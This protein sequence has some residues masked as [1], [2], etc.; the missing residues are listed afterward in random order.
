MV[1]LTKIP[2]VPVRN[3]TSNCAQNNVAF[4]SNIKLIEK[5]I[6][7]SL[8]NQSKV[9]KF[10]NYIQKNEG[11][12]MNILVNAVGT[13]LVAPFFIAFN[14]ISKE[15][16]NTKL[17]SALRQPISAALA[18]ITQVGVVTKFNKYI[19]KLAVN[20]K[21]GKDYD[22]SI[23]P[24]AKY[25]YNQ[26]KKNNPNFTRDQ[27]WDEVKKIRK[28]ARDNAIENLKNK[29]IK[30]TGKSA[31]SAA[32]EAGDTI[33][34]NIST[35]NKRVNGLSKFLGLFVSLAIMPIT[36]TALNWLYPRMMEFFAPS[37]CKD[38]SDNS[39]GGEKCK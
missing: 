14:P 1:K 34:K 9:T 2:N 33:R 35:I 24:F 36:C 32:K 17:Y 26:V 11:E 21:L 22:M 18:I 37:L 39:Q 13:A 16:K 4:G 19:D 38:K 29:I 15:D 10:L 25:T 7:N 27:I 28:E 3:I 5:G 8:I 20:G 23:R 30:E 6:E 31:E 12:V